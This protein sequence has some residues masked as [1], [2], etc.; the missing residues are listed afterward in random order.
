MQSDQEG[1]FDAC[2]S[3]RKVA[4]S[5]VMTKPVYTVGMEEEL[6][7]VESL[8]TQHAIRHVPIVD[9]SNKLVGLISQRHLYKTRSPRK[10]PMETGAVYGDDKIVDGDSY[11]EK[12]VLDSYILKNVMMPNPPT[13]KANNS[14]ADSLKI[15]IEQKIGCVIIIDDIQHVVGIITR[16][17]IM[18]FVYKLI[19]Q[20]K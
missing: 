6:S 16:L 9:M 12:S 13:L 1:G 5:S 8:F 10:L 7:V 19:N 20:Q 4:I 18:K 15:M 2:L 11:Y 17:D 14:L 3:M